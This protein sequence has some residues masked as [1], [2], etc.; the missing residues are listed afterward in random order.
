MNSYYFSIFVGPLLMISFL[1]LVYDYVDLRCKIP[2]FPN[3]LNVMFFVYC[4]HLMVV[5]LVGGVIR[6][7]FGGG[8]LVRL[9]AYFILFQTFWLDILL[10]N[11]VKRIAPRLYNIASGGRV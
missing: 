3:S 2:K 9:C 1:W 4:A 7:C 11:L 8:L 6:V 5:C 10:A